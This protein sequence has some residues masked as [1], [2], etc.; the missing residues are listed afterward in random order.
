MLEWLTLAIIFGC[1]AR[2]FSLHLSPGLKDT[3]FRAFR[4][5]VRPS[6]NDETVVVVAC[7][8]TRVASDGR[9][10]G[11]G[12]RSPAARSLHLGSVQWSSLQ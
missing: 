7:Y 10:D 3:V 2:C 6:D 9:T 12:Q 1:V 8:L 5:R 11:Q 4:P